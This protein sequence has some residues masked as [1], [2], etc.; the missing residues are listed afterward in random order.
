MLQGGYFSLI[1]FKQIRSSR[2]A[3]TPSFKDLVDGVRKPAFGLTLVSVV[4]IKGKAKK[5]ASTAKNIISTW[6][7]PKTVNI[8]VRSFKKDA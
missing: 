1:H 4:K 3:V 6:P 7:S 2:L 5:N 8:W